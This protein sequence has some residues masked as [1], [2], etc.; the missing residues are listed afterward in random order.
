[1]G[2]YLATYAATAV[3]FFALDFLWLGVVAK[4]WYRDRLGTLL[5]ET[6]AV[7]PAAAFYLCYVVGVVVFCVV[8]AAATGSWSKAL[9]LGLLFGL[10]AYGTYDMTNLATLRGWPAS[11][12]VV[13]M[14]W[15]AIL[16]G[17]SAVAGYM[18]MR[19]TM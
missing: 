19:T 16:T 1:M 8:P 6:V 2:R 9:T 15:G 13:D 18:V 5:A 3:V 4:S 11:V 12:A 10:L 7:L 17:V 14:V